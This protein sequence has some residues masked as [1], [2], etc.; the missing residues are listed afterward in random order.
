MDLATQ[1]LMSG[2]AGAG[3]APKHI[4]DYF[5]QH[6]WEGYGGAKYL[7]VP[8]A[9]ENDFNSV[10]GMVL[11]K[12]YDDDYNYPWLLFD[13]ER[14]NSKALE[15]SDGNAEVTTYSV[16][17][18]NSYITVGG[19][20]RGVN[21]GS[22]SSNSD[23][24]YGKYI[25]IIFRRED[26]FFKMGSYNGQGS[27]KT[28]T[29][30]MKSTPSMIWIKS[31]SDNRQWVCWH[32][33]YSTLKG[34]DYQWRQEERGNAYSS[35]KINSVNDTTFTLS[36][37]SDVTAS[38]T[39][40]T[41][42]AFGGEEEIWG[43][44][45]DQKAIISG[46]VNQSVTHNGGEMRVVGW[47][48]QFAIGRKMNN[49]NT[50]N[51]SDLNR[52]NT[53]VYSEMGTMNLGC[54]GV[55]R[56]Q[57]MAFNREENSDHSNT[58]Q[59]HTGTFSQTN[60]GLWAGDELTRSSD[61]NC[62]TIY[63]AVRTHYDDS[64]NGNKNQICRNQYY[65]GST[66]G[67]KYF[68]G[69]TASTTYPQ[70]RVDWM[71]IMKRNTNS[72]HRKTRLASRAKWGAWLDYLVQDRYW[73]YN[74]RIDMSHNQNG[75]I[76]YGGTDNWYNSGSS[77]TYD[78]TYL[79]NTPGVI[80]PVTWAGKGTGNR[81]LPH[82]LQVKPELFVYWLG[83]HMGGSYTGAYIHHIGL[84]NN[85][86]PGVNWWQ[87]YMTLQSDDQGMSQTA[88]TALISQEPTKDNLYLGGSLNTSGQA[89]YG[90]IMASKTGILKIG[91]YVGD[92]NAEQ[93]ID[94][95]FSNG[96]RAIIIK[97][98]DEAG[99]QSAPGYNTKARYYFF[100]AGRGLDNDN[101]STKTDY[102]VD[103]KN[104]YGEKKWDNSSSYDDNGIN[105]LASGF[106]ACQPNAQAANQVN[107]NAN[108][109]K[110]IFVA[111]AN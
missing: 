77:Q 16:T 103:L 106:T 109:G 62:D 93:D 41:W 104:Q 86:N 35:T 32:R 90:M 51:G 40:F 2:A 19:N 12:H 66:S 50:S 49:I 70:Q 7:A 11:I 44:K 108:N 81:T 6:G 34:S 89:W 110:Y 31:Y 107:L 37:H 83:D 22:G 59:E 47:R 87:H 75:P 4:S 10:G 48:P 53:C 8:S 57:G 84:G 27:A 65:S 88:S 101:S 23:T 95:G 3:G 21:G 69:M 71:M 74:A 42:Y 45:G 20:Q 9:S 100:G 30:G 25:G 111:F 29:H 18:N 72:G 26:H 76:G 80:M 92:G 52:G 85:E 78:V 63:W 96:I 17:F 68:S 1:R 46:T 91:H 94:C 14:G 39:N 64:W 105:H 38:G 79:Q 54:P 15:M 55:E 36:N 97:R 33:E 28:I 102:W 99:C 56:R 67:R 82:D 43:P 13:T 60:E 73:Q 98:F 5:V 61:G 24:G 58:F